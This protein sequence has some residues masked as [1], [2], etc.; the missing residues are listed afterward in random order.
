MLLHQYNDTKT[1][2][3]VLLMM[4]VYYCISLSLNSLSKNELKVPANAQSHTAENELKVPANAQSHT[5][6]NE[7]NMP[8]NEQSHTAVTGR[9]FRNNFSE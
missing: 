3:E 8:A 7:L 6:E 5:A 2:N 9:R 1:A 4:A